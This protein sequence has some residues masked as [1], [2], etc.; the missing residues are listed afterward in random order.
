M[1]LIR[2][3]FLILLA[4]ALGPIAAHADW[5][6][7][8]G[9]EK[10]PVVAA[11]DIEEDQV[12]LRLE[13]SSDAYRALQPP[14][15]AEPGADRTWLAQLLK[16]QTGADR[17]L[18]G[19]LKLYQLREASGRGHQPPSPRHIPA[20]DAEAGQPVHYAEILYPLTRKPAVLRFIPP[21]AAEDS[22]PEIG[23]IVYHSGVPVIDYRY[24]K[25]KEALDLDWEDP[26]FT[27]FRNSR[28]KRHH[29]SP[30][31]SF[32]YI[33]PFEVRHEILIRVRDLQ[34]LL[35][36]RSADRDLATAAELEALKAQAGRFL[37]GREAVRI[38]GVSVQ[39]ILDQ[40]SFVRVEPDGLKTLEKTTDLNL[41]TALLGVVFAYISNGIP[42]AV[43][44]DWNLFPPRVRQV[45]VSV[46]DPAGIFESYVTRDNPRI[47]WLNELDQFDF[48]R[49]YRLPEIQ[50]L[51]AGEDAG[52]SN[53]YLA[54]SMVA[55][56]AVIVLLIWWAV[57]QPGRSRWLFFAVPS[58]ILLVA[59]AIYGLKPGSA[60][61]TGTATVSEDRARVLLQGLVRNIYRA[62]D[63]RD[64]SDVYDKLALSVCEELIETIYLQN[65]QALEIERAGGS[66]ARVQSVEILDL[67]VESG[68]RYPAA[69]QSRVG[70]AATG[71][72]SHWG[73]SHTRTNHYEAVVDTR[74]ED[75]VW[76][77]CALELREGQRA[78]VPAQT[79]DS[80]GD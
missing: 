23:M 13:L 38:N 56:V 70:W 8:T 62:F 44:V 6:H 55:A 41:S 39:P 59:G 30:L 74:A 14:A 65:R 80:A 17:Y 27:R 21:A 16:L 73:H 19:E 52:G 22:G 26:W 50:A 40:M 7:Q 57:R 78:A 15:S 34:A 10:A 12:R 18:L 77:I 45:P 76:K 2:L 4:I 9:A 47:E 33:E 29:E 67:E 58:L 20:A 60:P 63:F 61:L 31:M 24:L 68:S 54:L 51:P 69:F 46:Y 49:D 3:G 79:T 66:R 32:L 37:S 72:V 42:D 48:T 71:T 43:T 5:S 28:L 53:R 11:F 64:E 75:G 1:L 35:D 36:L 25:Q